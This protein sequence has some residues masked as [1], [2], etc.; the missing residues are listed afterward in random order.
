MEFNL[1]MAFVDI[2]PVIIYFIGNVKMLKCCYNKMTMAQFSMFSCGTIMLLCGG[3]CK[4]IW[5][6][7]YVLSICNYTTLSECFFPMQSFAF[8]LLGFSLSRMLKKKKQ[9]NMF[10][11]A[12]P[13]VNSH[14]PFILITF[15]VT[16][17]MCIQLIKISWQLNKKAILFIVLFLVGIIGQ[18][19]VSS[20]TNSMPVET[21]ATF[22]W[23][24]EG[25]HI[26]TQLMFLITA[27]ILEKA[28]F[29]DEDCFS[30]KSKI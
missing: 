21:M 29:A 5:K 28:N 22:H 3:L 9:E 18:A 24:A 10:Y 16:T 26:L 1:P 27:I 14:M 30:I 25:I 2:I 4:I 12:I 20:I 13:I 17:Y 8:F 15:L 19:W 6:F 11:S 23:I 7:L